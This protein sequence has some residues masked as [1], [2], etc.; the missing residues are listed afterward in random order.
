LVRKLLLNVNSF[1]QSSTTCEVSTS[2]LL[3]IYTFTATL[4]EEMYQIF[5]LHAR[6]DDNKEKLLLILERFIYRT[7][8]GITQFFLKKSYI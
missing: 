2:D 8:F 3:N 7:D 4:A 6:E 5:N 1:R